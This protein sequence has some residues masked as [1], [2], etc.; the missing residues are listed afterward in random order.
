MAQNHHMLAA[1]EQAK[2]AFA[3]GEVPVGAVVVD[4]TSGEVIAAAH[5][6]TESSKDPSAHAEILAIKQA[7]L[8]NRQPRINACDL[9]VT[10]EPCPMCATAISFARIR[11]VYFGAYDVKGGAVDHGVKIYNNQPNLY[12]PEVY[13]GIEEQECAKLLKDFFKDKR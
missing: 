1:I 10:L 7:C 11:R 2:K 9:Y 13:G 8:K 12:V 3:M 6:L 4:S 5:N